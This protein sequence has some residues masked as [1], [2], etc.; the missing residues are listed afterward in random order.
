MTGHTRVVIFAA[1]ALLLGVTLTLASLGFPGTLQA[2]GEYGELLAAIGLE[3]RAAVNAVSAVLFDL[4]PADTLGEALALFVASA[5][6]QLVLRGLAG[7]ERRTLPRTS[8]P[9]RTTPV[10]SDAVRSLALGLVVPL[11]ALAAFVSV[12][13]HLTVGGGLQGGALASSALATLFLAGRYRAQR[14]IAP[15]DQLD[16]LE[17]FSIGGYVV[18]GLAGLVLGTAF[19]ENV[20]PL[21]ATGALLSSGTIQLLSVLVA[22]EAAAAVVLVLGEIQE[23]PL[24]REGSP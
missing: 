7:E 16:H 4:R 14:R 21:G 1:G 24:E 6:L 17:A 18:V 3:E 11:L 19:L 5:G 13:G 10:T 9:G 23:E 15:E 2:P 20:L 12:Q 22:I 8:I